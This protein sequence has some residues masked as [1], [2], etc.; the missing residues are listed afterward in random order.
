MTGEADGPP[1]LPSIPLGDTLS[2][3]SGAIGALVA[4]YHKKVN[5]GGGQH[6]DVSFYEPVLTLLQSDD[7]RVRPGG[8]RGARRARTGSRIPTGVPRNVY[9]TERRPLAG[10][11]GY[12]RSSGG[13]HP[14]GHRCRYAGGQGEVRAQRR[15]HRERR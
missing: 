13:P 8:R 7:H 15:S 2:A 11:V 9:R 3:M 6:V 10:A 12:D 1:M 4:C 5:G 14:H